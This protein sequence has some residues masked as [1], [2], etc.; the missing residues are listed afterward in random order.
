MDEFDETL[1]HLA[2]WVTEVSPDSPEDTAALVRHNLDSIGCA[3]G[4]YT[5][6]VAGATRAIAAT[7]TAEGG[8][9]VIGQRAKTSPEYA[10]FANATMVRYLDFNDNYLRNGGGHTSDLIPAVLAVAEQRHL[11]GRQFLDA[12][13]VGYEVFAAF[14]DAVRLRD[15]GWDYPTFLGYAASA[16]VARAMGLTAEQTANALSMTVTPSLA[17][18]ITRVGPLANWKGLASPFTAMNAV[19]TGQLAAA[20]LTGPPHV[21]DGHRGLKQLATGPFTLEALGVSQDGRTAAVR[22]SYKLFVAEFNAQGPVGVFADLHREGIR[23]VDIESIRVG[24]YEVAWSEIG[25]GQDDHDVKWD[26][27]NKETADH[28]MPYMIVVTL[29]DGDIVRDSY[30][31][32]RILDPALRPLMN[33]IEVVVD[34]DITANWDKEPAHQIDI[35]LTS[36]EHRSIRSVFPKGHP[37]NPATD[38]ELFHKFRRQSEPVIGESATGEVLDALLGVEAMADV[39]ELA[40]LL[41][42]IEVTGT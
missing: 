11:S 17:L 13:H 3:L 24:T 6:P 38:E 1:R 42:E 35:V 29:T 39:T 2:R 18:G 21:F 32:E 33:R 14:A 19:F 7:A 34:D 36:G 20:G 15:A 8:A 5:H 40:R 12:L 25:G 16:G 22:S 41:A 4:S 31:P 23:P 37:D 30:L 9:S 27:Q 26:P 28:S 10:T